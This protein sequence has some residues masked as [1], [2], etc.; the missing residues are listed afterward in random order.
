ME[1]TQTNQNESEELDSVV[2]C[3][4]RKLTFTDAEAKAQDE[5]RLL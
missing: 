5:L 3:K 1:K 2:R 4:I